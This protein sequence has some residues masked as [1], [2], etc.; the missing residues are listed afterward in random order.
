[1]T[2]IHETAYPR[3]RSN[4]SDA[5]L[6]ELYTPTPSDLA[7]A[8]RVTKSAGMELG[9]LVLLKTFQRLGYFPRFDEL[10]P[11]LLTHIA[12]AL[13]TAEPEAQLQRYEARSRRWR[14]LPL[15]REYLGIT[16]F[17]DGGRR[18]LL[19]AMLDAARSKDI[20]ADIINV[21]I[22]A[23][24]HARYELPAFSTLQRVGLK[25]RAQV[26][27]G[28]YQQVFTALDDVQHAMLTRLLT[29]SDT[30]PTS[31]WQRLKREPRQ[32]TPKQLREHLA[33]ARWL[34][35]LNTARHTLDGIP[36]TKLQRFADEARALNVARMNETLE[37]KRVT[38]AVA[39]I[40]VRTAQALDDLAEMFIRRMQKLHNKAK[41]ALDEYRRQHQE[42][43]D[44]LVA[45][46]ERIVTGWQ[47]SD[48]PKQRLQTIDALIGSDADTIR[49]R[50]EAHLAYAGNNYLPFLPR[51]FRAQRKT[52]L[53]V[54]AFLQPTST[55]T[56]TTLEKAIRFVVQHRDARTATLPIGGTGQPDEEPLDVSW[57]PPSWWKVVTGTSRREEPFATV[58]RKYL[59]LCVFSCA[60]AELKSA[61]L[62][63]AGSEH[64]SDHRDQL[65]TWEE[66]EKLV[67]PYCQQI[68][69]AA[70]ATQFVHDL[71]NQLSQA[72]LTA[73]AA[74]PTNTSLTIKDGEPVLRR[75]EKQ[76]EPPGF[77][78]IDRLLTERLP[79]CNIIDV[80]TDTEHWLHWT[81]AFGPLSGFEGRLVSPAQRYVT[82]TFCY[83]C[84]LGPTQ[85]TRSLKGLDRFQVA[86]VNQRHITEQNLLDANVAVINRYNRFMLPK[87]WGSGKRA[88]ADGTKWDVYEQNLLSE[89]HIRY[90]GWGGI[91]YYH[92]SDTYIAL[93][94]HFIACG[95]WEAV[96]ILDGL[97]ENRSEIR[98]DTLHADTQGQSETVFGLAYLLAIQLMP[99]I[100]NWKELTLYAPTPRFVTEHVEHLRDLF[101][102]TAAWG[103]IRTHLPDMLRVAISIS[104]GKIRSSTILRKL[105]TESRKNRLYVAFRELGRVVRTIFLLQ[106]INDEELRRTITASTNTVEAWNQFVQWVAFGG[107]GVIRQNNREEQ[108]KIIR[109]NHLVAN[110][111]VFHNVAAMTRGLQDL[112][113]EGYAV[114]PEIIAGFSPYKTGH[115]NRFGSY[116][117]HFDQVPEP[118]TEELRLSPVSKEG[119]GKW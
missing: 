29:R 31:L 9:L 47:A 84:Y 110:L 103:L 16:A 11:R 28:Y 107:E 18:V 116:N 44:A 69:I 52:C 40:R 24:V 58:D 82:T 80:L 63:I 101:S 49:D 64:F 39:L 27:T 71:Q 99:R 54:L 100:R 70:D 67:D 79:E 36:E 7:F 22:E 48:R 60:M 19:S 95:V 62:C 15:V 51:L 98:P 77:A 3:I 53:S 23:L 85:T 65:V 94:S 83:G 104:Q 108:R 20:L 118:V 72:I 33:Q 92:I 91:G 117:P 119:S 50:C 56:D 13:E 38:L 113:D 105:G 12:A 97:L 112:V 14:H 2:A 35:S 45:L 90:G 106:F 57:I 46:L 73:D 32:P 93:F 114:T 75:L 61:D 4:L 17:S 76:P 68:G 81:S 115:I 1:M 42:Q 21:G 30:D 43:T 6:Q 78:Q 41:E 8:R 74:F 25:A 10:P 66:Y 26:N 5:E 55:S 37:A 88:A 102:D 96:Y 87:L 34:Q 109:Y 59:E 111:V 89:Y 86:Y